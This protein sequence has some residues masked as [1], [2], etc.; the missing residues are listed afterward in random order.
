MAS[1]DGALKGANSVVFV[2]F[3]K[4]KVA[5][6]NS[7]RRALQEQEVGYQVAKKTLLKR[8]R[9]THGITPRSFRG[10]RNR[11]NTKRIFQL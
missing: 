5:D 1:L 9:S 3:D 2:K 11:K 6:V 10:S 4:L 8:A 7:L